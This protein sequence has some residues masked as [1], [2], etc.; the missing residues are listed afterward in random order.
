MD[1][2][3]IP[4][5]ELRARPLPGYLERAL[6]FASLDVDPD[7]REQLFARGRERHDDLIRRLVAGP[8]SSWES[9]SEDGKA[10]W[11]C[12]AAV[13]RGFMAPMRALDLSDLDPGPNDEHH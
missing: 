9:L 1:I 11:A 4:P 12:E 8:N 13:E 6:E 3:N 7:T 10:V 2:T 5:Q